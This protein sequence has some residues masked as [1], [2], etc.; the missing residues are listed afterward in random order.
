MTPPLTGVE[1]RLLLAIEFFIELVADFS[2]QVVKDLIPHFS[3][4]EVG[5]ESYSVLVKPLVFFIRPSREDIFGNGVLR[6]H[7][8]KGDRA[9]L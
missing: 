1:K 8:D 9:G 2:R 3:S 4:A 7:G 5:I 6:P